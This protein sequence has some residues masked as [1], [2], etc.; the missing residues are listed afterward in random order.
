RQRFDQHLTGCDPCIVYL[1][2][3]RQTIATLGR[4][5]EESV[6]QNVLDTLLE[7]FR[8]WPRERG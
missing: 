5:P 4:L 8:R 2:Q 1:D 7:H 6:P 3:M